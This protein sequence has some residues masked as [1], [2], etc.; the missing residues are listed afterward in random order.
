MRGF[1]MYDNG[2]LKTGRISLLLFLCLLLGFGAIFSLQKPVDKAVVVVRHIFA[3]TPKAEAQKVEA[4]K[5]SL[6]EPEKAAPQPQP[7]PVKMVQ[8]TPAPAAAA[9]V[10]V[11]EVKT[12]KK[13]NKAM[14]KRKASLEKSAAT[15]SQPEKPESKKA[16]SMA[17]ELIQTALK[18]AQISAPEPVIV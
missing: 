3:A 12:E 16:E 18:T 1:I 5:K 4:P 14:E 17:E 6:K 9:A 8:T 7:E 2:R 15:Q 13:D 10:A 11:D